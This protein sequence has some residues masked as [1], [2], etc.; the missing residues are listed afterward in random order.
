MQRERCECQELWID[1]RPAKPD[2]CEYNAANSFL[3]A[4]DAALN[5]TQLL[6]RADDGD[7]DARAQAVAAAYDRLRELA[8]AK[9]AA[10]RQNH[11][12]TSTALV[13]EVSLKLLDE[14]QLPMASRGQFLA[15]ASKAMRNLLIDHART[16]GRQKRGGGRERYSFDEAMQACSEQR[17]DFLALNEALTELAEIEPRKAHVVEMRYFGG[18]SNQEIAEALDTSLATVKR[19]W[20]VAKTWLQKTLREGDTGEADE[21]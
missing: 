11:T 19:D 18:L 6:Q 8:T 7:P 9:M 17:D 13:H 12:L 14:S 21:S 2:R 15:Y 3:C 10:E 4:Q 1:A 5:I 20:T 16:K